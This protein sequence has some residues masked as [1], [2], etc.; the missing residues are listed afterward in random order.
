MMAE[1]RWLLL[2]SNRV[3][4]F[5]LAVP[6]D[7]IRPGDEVKIVGVSDSECDPYIE[8]RIEDPEQTAPS[9]SEENL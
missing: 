2:E 9:G 8:I 1:I 5:K 6:E 7:K 3:G 4:R